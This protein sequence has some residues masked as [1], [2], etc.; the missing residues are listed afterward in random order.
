MWIKLVDWLVFFFKLFSL[1]KRTYSTFTTKYK[2]FEI[3]ISIY[4]KRREKSKN[5]ININRDGIIKLTSR[6]STVV[7]LYTT[8]QHYTR[9]FFYSLIIKLSDFF[10]ITGINSI[11]I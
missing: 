10:I 1:H 3:K 5:E 11:I 2:S 4:P 9:L 8:L 6:T 7:L